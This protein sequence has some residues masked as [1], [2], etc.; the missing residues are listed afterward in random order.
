MHKVS[1]SRHHYLWGGGMGI[2]DFVDL[3]TSE[4]L[5]S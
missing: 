5:F 1:G 4:E 2:V 3:R